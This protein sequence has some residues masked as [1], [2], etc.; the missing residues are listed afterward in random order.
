MRKNNFINDLLLIAIYLLVCIFIIIIPF[1]CLIPITENKA[2]PVVIEFKLLYSP[3]NNI[4]SIK[5]EERNRK[6][7]WFKYNQVFTGIYSYMSSEKKPIILLGWVDG[8]RNKLDP[9]KNLKVMK[10]VYS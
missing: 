7:I 1:N 8:F 4:F 5:I 2:M 10:M 9:V 3:G 6:N